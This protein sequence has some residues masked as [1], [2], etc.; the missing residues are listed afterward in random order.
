MRLG[1]RGLIRPGFLIQLLSLSQTAAA[2]CDS[3]GPA[4]LGG[5]YS[6]T[7]D[8]IKAD[9]GTRS[10]QLPLAAGC[11]FRPA[12][13]QERPRRRLSTHNAAAALRGGVDQR[14]RSW[15]RPPLPSAVGFVNRG[16]APTADSGAHSGQAP[17]AAPDLLPPPNHHIRPHGSPNP[18]VY[19]SKATHLGMGKINMQKALQTNKRQRTWSPAGCRT[20]CSHAMVA[21]SHTR[22]SYCTSLSTT[23]EAPDPLMSLHPS[24]ARHRAYCPDPSTYASTLVTAA[25]VPTVHIRM[26]PSADALKSRSPITT[27]P[28]TP[29]R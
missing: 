9:R 13:P 20:V 27:S 4:Q 22:T 3:A 12:A 18:P 23:T 7:T 14:R 19:T 6:L 1:R 17:T 24:T 16:R 25:H 5:H 10:A 8:S 15:C 2:V 26:V 28:Y 11:S 29:P 21:G